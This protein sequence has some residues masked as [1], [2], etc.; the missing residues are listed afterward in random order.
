ME[1]LKPDE[2]LGGRFRREKSIGGF[3]ALCVFLSGF[4]FIAYKTFF[5]TPAT[6]KTNTPLISEEANS[7]ISRF[8]LGDF[9]SRLSGKTIGV[10]MDLSREPCDQA[11][12]KNLGDLL[13]TQSLRRE[14]AN[15]YV[16]FSNSC[17]NAVFALRSAANIFS[18][19]ISD[20]AAAIP[21]ANQI[22]KSEPYMSS[23]YY[24]RGLANFR[25]NNNLEAI[26]DFTT[27][28]ELYVDKSKMNSNAFFRLS[29]SYERL[30]E[31][32]SAMLPLYD[33]IRIKPEKN[34]TTQ[35]K[36]MLSSLNEKGK[37][38]PSR[39]G[40]DV[41]RREGSVVK[42]PV[43]I[44]GVRGIF[45]LDTG[46]SFLTIKASFAEK[47]RVRIFE[48]SNVITNTANG[49][50]TAKRGIAADVSL[51]NIGSRNVP[52]LVQE[53]KK[54]LY[55]DNIDGLLGNSFLSRF[56]MKFDTSSVVISTRK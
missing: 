23:G 13:R 47:S 12:M 37:C 5:S 32:C 1:H 34:D 35:T 38:D 9:K 17:P 50:A 39:K 29:E 30:S 25:A 26:D 2:R 36:K 45:I 43:N 22:V 10:L 56:D 52:I 20:Y 19:E 7:A 54:G 55:G 33:W 16:S 40:E 24:I 27:S 31:F 6:V 18:N 44:N 15:A 3:L 14:A 4:G 46:A 11:A 41:F 48:G 21:I 8:G 51:V 28:I 49:T 53:E 42:I